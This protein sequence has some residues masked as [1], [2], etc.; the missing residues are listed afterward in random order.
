[1]GGPGGL[2]GEAGG[3]AICNGTVCGITITNCPF[4]GNRANGGAGGGGGSDGGLLYSGGNGGNASGGAFLNRGGD[5]Q[6]MNV[7]VV[8]NESSGGARGSGRPFGIPGTASG[9]GVESATAGALT[10]IGNTLVARNQTATIG[11]DV[12]G[13]ITSAGHI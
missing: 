13:P 1:M 4:S 10:A 12:A 2:G 3:G 11:P 9:G 6:F 5:A 8:D 7:T